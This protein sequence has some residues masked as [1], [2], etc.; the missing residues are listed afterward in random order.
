MQKFSEIMNRSTI[1][2]ISFEMV[3]K[4]FGFYETVFSIVLMWV[5]MFLGILQSNP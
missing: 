2:V 1:A 5:G 4:G 3:S